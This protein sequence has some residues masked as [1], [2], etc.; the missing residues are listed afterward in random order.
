MRGDQ[1]E[2]EYIVLDA[3]VRDVLTLR[4]FRAELRNGHELVAYRPRRAGS[5]APPVRVGQTVRV[6][7]SPYDMGRGEV[8]AD[9]DEQV[10][11]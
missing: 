4:A 3:V 8:L 11:R 6:R 1:E 7:L 9:D 10:E 5:G 2:T